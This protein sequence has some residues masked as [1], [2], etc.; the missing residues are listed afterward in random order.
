MI[1]AGTPSSLATARSWL[2]YR[3]PMGWMAAAM[4]P[5]RVPYPS[6]ASV[7]L[8]VPHTSPSKAADRS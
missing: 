6:R 8:E 2:L 3:S 1:W 7:L 4:S 5:C